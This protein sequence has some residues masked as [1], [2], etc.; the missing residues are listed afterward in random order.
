MLFDPVRHLTRRP[1]RIK[2]VLCEGVGRERGG[3]KGAT[4]NLVRRFTPAA[5]RGKGSD[6][7]IYRVAILWVLL[8]HVTIALDRLHY[9][10]LAA[11]DV[12]D[13]EAHIAGRGLKL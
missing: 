7:L 4:S 12:C 13:R 2:L 5:N 1:V 10:P 11:H 6:E 9:L 3:A 8:R